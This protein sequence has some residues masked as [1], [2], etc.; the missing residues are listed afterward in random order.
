[1][2]LVMGRADSQRSDAT[3]AVVF[4]PD[5]PVP[6]SIEDAYAAHYTAVFRYALALT[7]SI[8]DAEDITAEVFARALDSWR[9]VP[10]RPLPWLLLVARRIATD[11]VRRAR[12]FIAALGGMRPAQ[13]PDAGEARTEFWD[14]FEAVGAILTER[15][16]EALV[17]RYERDLTDTE[18]GEIM[19]L[20]ESGVRSLVARAL[21]GLREHPR[22][23]DGPPGQGDPRCLRAPVLGH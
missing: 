23:C 2:D 4:A 10:P 8:P 20:S 1:M 3:D 7:R 19:G 16:R 12:R 11:R 14:W 15:Q 9:V 22:C 5:V 17:L 13:A 21:A 6:V 18:I